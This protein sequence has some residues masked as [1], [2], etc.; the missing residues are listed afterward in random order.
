MGT[1]SLAP[2]G[3]Q[4][5]YGFVSVTLLNRLM[6][7]PGCKQV[8]ADVFLLLQNIFIGSFLFFVPAL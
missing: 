8:A 1:L 5:I 4:L 2:S 3:G 6:C 7:S